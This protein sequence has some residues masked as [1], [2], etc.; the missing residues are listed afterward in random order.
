MNLTRKKQ[1]RK[2]NKRAPKAQIH[3]QAKCTSTGEVCGHFHH[4]RDSALRCGQHIFTG[5]VT[6]VRITGELKIYKED[7]EEEE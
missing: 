6:A 4:T 5:N 7:K 2:H 3:Y 1:A